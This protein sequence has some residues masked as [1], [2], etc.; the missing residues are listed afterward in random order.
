MASDAAEQKEMAAEMAE[1]TTAETVSKAILSGMTR[2]MT[3]ARNISTKNEEKM[4]AGLAGINAALGGISSQLGALAG[5]I[6]AVEE[7]VTTTS[8][9]VDLMVDS[10]KP[11]CCC[12]K[13]KSNSRFS[14]LRAVSASPVR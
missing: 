2:V 12:H 13:T 10:A 14:S 1:G 3:E 5:R 11:T 8:R 9:C 6:G 4:D 7:K